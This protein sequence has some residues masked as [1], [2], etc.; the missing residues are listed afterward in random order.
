MWLNYIVTNQAIRLRWPHKTKKC[1][2]PQTKLLLTIG[3]I[4]VLVNYEI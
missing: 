4:V 3:Y 1:T 2:K